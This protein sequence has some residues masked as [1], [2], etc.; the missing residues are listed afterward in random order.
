MSDWSNPTITTQYDVFVNEAKAR[1]VDAATMFMDTASLS[2]PPVGGIRF[3]RLG[4]GNYT[5]GEWD[6]AA[7]ALRYLSVSG[8]GTGTGDPST[9]RINLGLGSMAVQSSGAVSITGGNITNLTGFSVSTTIAFTAN[10]AS[11]LGSNASKCRRGYFG[12]ALVLPVG[13]DKYATS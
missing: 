12:D 10:N 1:D 9:A 11:D 4:S 3:N 13:V 8:G 7:F 5:L 2:N 6:G